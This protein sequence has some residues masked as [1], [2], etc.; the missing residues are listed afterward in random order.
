ML[1]N[2]MNIIN[3]SAGAPINGPTAAAI[4]ETAVHPR[5][6]AIPLRTVVYGFVVPKTIGR[7]NSAFVTVTKGIKTRAAITT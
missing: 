5:K 6:T 7:P 1:K 4:A 3:R 2:P